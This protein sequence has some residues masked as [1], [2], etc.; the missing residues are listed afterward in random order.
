MVKIGKQ[1]IIRE[2]DEIK[3]IFFACRNCSR[4]IGNFDEVKKNDRSSWT[5]HG[6]FLC[7]TTILKF[8]ELKDQTK[9]DIYC[10][11]NAQIGYTFQ[12]SEYHFFYKRTL[13]NI[14]L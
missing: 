11:C 12:N 9:I 14:L 13:Y 7:R 4:E 8:V 5:V 10:T 2:T 1:E 3:W 6:H